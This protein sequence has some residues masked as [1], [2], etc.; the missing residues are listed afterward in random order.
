MFKHIVQL[1]QIEINNNKIQQTKKTPFKKWILQIVILMMHNNIDII[2]NN[3]NP[4]PLNPLSTLIFVAYIK[5]QQK[6][7]E[8][9]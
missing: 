9:E 7:E 3:G 2:N 8:E 6:K 5:A 4:L 1:Y